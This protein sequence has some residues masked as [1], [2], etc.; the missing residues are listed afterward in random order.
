MTPSRF[1]VAR[2]SE[3]EAQ[4]IP[5]H[6]RQWWRHRE[7]RPALGAGRRF[8]IWL[9]R[10]LGLSRCNVLLAWAWLLRAACRALVTARAARLAALRSSQGDTTTQQTAL[11]QDQH[12]AIAR[13][14]RPRKLSST[15]ER[16]S[17]SPR[18]WWHGRHTRLQPVDVWCPGLW[19]DA[20]LRA[21]PVCGY[22][23]RV[24]RTLPRT[25]TVGICNIDIYIALVYPNIVS[26]GIEL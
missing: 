17:P 8:A 15:P 5:P 12:R 3:Q 10:G 24:V 21:D 7:F 25:R 4:N 1:V 22:R 18:A 11:T 13:H 6:S 14:N 20:T 23:C 9:P 19:V 16:T 2:A 26:H